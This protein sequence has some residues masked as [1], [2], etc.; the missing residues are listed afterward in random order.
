MITLRSPHNPITVANR[1]KVAVGSSL[2]PETPSGVTGHG[3]DAEMTLNYHRKGTQNGFTR[4][5]V[6]E[7]AAE[8]NGTII[9]GKFGLPKEARS[10]ACVWYGFLSIFILV[11]ASVTVFTD[12]PFLWSAIFMGIPLFM[13]A[14][15]GVAFLAGRRHA[16]D[17]EKAIL[18]FLKDVIDAA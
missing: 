2:T 18:A 5:F 8:G 10:F 3:T 13:M 15:V 11:G 14:I 7:M 9:T 16:A 4:C 12:V 6:A 1:L 17:D